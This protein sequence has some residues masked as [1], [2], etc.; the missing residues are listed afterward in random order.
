MSNSGPGSPRRAEGANAC[1]ARGSFHAVLLLLASAAAPAHG[2]VPAFTEVRDTYAASEA[3]LLDRHG[4]LIHELRVD[5][6][7]RRLDWVP[8]DQISPATVQAV[9]HAEDRRFQDHSGVDWRALGAAAVR[10][11]W[12]DNPRGAS[13]IT[14][15][16]A[17]WLD[18]ALKPATRRTVG[19]KW[20]QV[21]AARE[22]ESQWTKAQIL[23]A[24]FNLV[25]FRSELQGIAAGARGLFDKHPSGLGRDESLLL[26]ALLRAPNAMAERVGER[27]CLLGESLEW[28]PSC[29]ALSSL[30][31]ERLNGPLRV[32]PLMAD[33]P[34]VARALLAQG[35]QR[36]VVSTIDGDLQRFTQA[37]LRQQ[38]ETLGAERVHDG[39]VLVADRRTGEVLA[40]VGNRGEG[41]VDGVKA[42]R[43]AGSTLKPFLY[44]L[45]IEQRLLTAASLL[46]DSPLNVVTPTGLYVP[47][48]YDRDFKGPVSLR[49]SLGNSLN[50]PAV[51]T[52]VLIGA[53][54]FVE[55]LRRLGFDGLQEDGEFYGYALALGS[56]DVSLWQ[57]VNGYRALANGGAYS[58]LTLVKRSGA[59]PRRILARE[60]AFIISDILADRGARGLTFGLDNVLATGYWSAVKTGTSKDMR[61]NWCVGYSDRFVVGV[62]VGNFSGEPMQDVSGVTGAAPVW[63]EVMNYLHRGRPSRTPPPPGDLV[64][65]EVRFVPAVEESRR[66][67]FLR[68]TEMAEV[69][70]PSG[71]QR[72]IVRIVYPARGSILAADPDIPLPNQRLFFEVEG[73][74]SGYG[75]R[76]DGAPVDAAVGWAPQRGFH[77]VVLV[78][79]TGG[80]LDQADFEVRGSPGAAALPGR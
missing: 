17:A 54:A 60:P 79:A 76:V 56:A 24:Y 75:L 26:A 36:R 62:W 65:A 34:H 53:D 33:A 51:R 18:P 48:N 80:E 29:S 25:Y 41:Y 50:V 14:M 71:T 31:R 3:Q 19:Q 78:D 30:A 27:A 47:S 40:Y 64:S 9:T 2:A 1:S 70:L 61:D 8:L 38:L 67:W 4:E 49:N 77:R 43:Q 5:A 58:T 37:A 63:L 69:R 45:A 42:M 73:A 46:D 52:L 39:A 59:R 72:K 74:E 12:E 7:V 66:E 11:L 35:G 21:Q 13:T 16:L 28:N 10:S 44:E 23:E 6:Q 57:L 55:R 20:D 15:Q 68:G 22:L 32:R